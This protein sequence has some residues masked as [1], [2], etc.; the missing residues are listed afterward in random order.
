MAMQ[1]VFNPRNRQINPVTP[2]T[3]VDPTL[4]DKVVSPALYALVCKGKISV[5]DIAA[6][7]A[8]NKSP[9]ILLKNQKAVKESVTVTAPDNK[10]TV[11]E[12]PDETP[13]ETPEPKETAATA[14]GAFDGQELSHKKQP[15]LLII[16]AT[17]G[18]DVNAEG[19][20]PTRGNLIKAIMARAAAAEAGTAP[21]AIPPI[22]E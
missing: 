11:T 7:F 5:E 15:E 9:E 21:A 17:V 1:Y 10:E 22:A 19:F 20:A 18:V 6:L 4:R 16:A 14:D 3:F 8:V 13:A 2:Q 12:T